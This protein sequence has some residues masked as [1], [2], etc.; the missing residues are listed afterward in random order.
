[1]L[2]KTL[3]AL[4]VTG[5]FMS[6]VGAAEMAPTSTRM[7]KDQPQKMEIK[8][9]STSVRPTMT[10]VTEDTKSDEN[11]R[12]MREIQYKLKMSYK[13]YS[14]NIHVLDGVVTVTGTV[15]TSQDKHNV[16]MDIS[17]IKGVKKVVNNLE[18]KNTIPK[19]NNGKA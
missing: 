14:I 13:N 16:E 1:M 12:V 4:S 5:L 8:I 9:D 11:D 6:F 15:P 7:T 18:A 17:G 10:N 19:V 3:I 2:N